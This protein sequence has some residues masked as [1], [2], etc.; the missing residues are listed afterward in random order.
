MSPWLGDILQPTSD[1]PTSL[2][3]EPHLTPQCSVTN[4]STTSWQKADLT[5]SQTNKHPDDS[6]R[7][8]QQGREGKPKQ[9]GG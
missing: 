2:L 4:P 8:H 1:T 3:T 9:H 6:H 7:A 5:T